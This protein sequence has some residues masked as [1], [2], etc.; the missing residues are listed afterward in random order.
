MR[1]TRARSAPKRYTEEVTTA[2]LHEPP[3]KQKQWGNQVFPVEVVD[4]NP[5]FIKLHYTGWSVSW[6]T[7]VPAGADDPAPIV[8]W[9]A[10][11][12]MEAAADERWQLLLHYMAAEIKK[13]LTYHRI[14]QSM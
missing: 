9:I 13:S 11:P 10:R 1:S 4:R 14:R 2:K 3:P 7:W 12:E 6:D 5:G 8:K